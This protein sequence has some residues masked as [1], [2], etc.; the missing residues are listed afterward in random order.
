MLIYYILQLLLFVP[1]AGMILFLLPE[2]T[3]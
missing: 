2:I 3:A 1:D